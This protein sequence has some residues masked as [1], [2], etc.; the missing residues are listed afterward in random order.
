MPFVATLWI[1]VYWACSKSFPLIAISSPR[2]VVFVS[3]D[4]GGM[5]WKTAR[6]GWEGDAMGS[7]TAILIGVGQPRISAWPN[8]QVA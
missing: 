8:S 1:S 4:R 5:S 2:F 7:L 3:G 6:W